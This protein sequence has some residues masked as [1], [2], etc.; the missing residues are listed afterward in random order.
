MKAAVLNDYDT[1]LSAPEFVVYRDVPEPKIEAP[2]DI[3]VRIGG[4]GVCRTDLDVIEGL[5]RDRVSVKLPYIMGHEN[6]GWVE[7][8]GSAVQIVKTGDPVICH[9]LLSKGEALAARRG[10]D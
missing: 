9:P 7:A 8:V 5:W 2:G 1:S 6:A 3:I 10:N 4:A